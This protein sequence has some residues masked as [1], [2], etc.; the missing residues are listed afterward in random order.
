MTDLKNL[1]L[2]VAL[3]GSFCTFKKAMVMLQN[4]VDLG[5]DVYPIMSFNAYSISTRFGS[6]T[7]FIDQV[8]TITGKPIIHSIHD[9]EPLGPKSMIDALL[10]APC[11]G[12]TL[13]KID[14]A[15]VDTPVVLA[16]KSLMRNGKPIILAIS[17]NDGLGLNLENIGHLMPN[18]N[19]YFVPFGQ[20]NYIA[21]PY[22]LVADLSLVPDTIQLALEG[23]QI[24]PVIVKY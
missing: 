21:K 14:H 16:A 1:K 3:C 20:D 6:A 23:K 12:N 17:T 5:V 15:I 11:T 10:I 2:G 22:S 7:D 4:L 13:S 9:A 24:Q 18:Q 8:E 19:I